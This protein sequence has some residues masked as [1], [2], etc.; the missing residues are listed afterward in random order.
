M[1]GLF[2]FGCEEDN[3]EIQIVEDEVDINWIIIKNPNMHHFWSD[4]SD[5]GYYFY[6]TKSSGVDIGEN[7]LYREDLHSLTLHPSNNGNLIF[8]YNDSLFSYNLSDSFND[9]LNINFI[10]SDT[11]QRIIY[12][13]EMDYVTIFDEGTFGVEFNTLL[14]NELMDYR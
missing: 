3:T 7:L 4:I 11:V 12:H 9:S 14:P 13:S 10:I 5:I 8:T 1:L 6:Y 2:F